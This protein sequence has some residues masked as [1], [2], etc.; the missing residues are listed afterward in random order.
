M[1][2]AP[3]FGRFFLNVGTAR[4]DI[5]RVK[6]KPFDHQPPIIKDE[7]FKLQPDDGLPARQLLQRV[8]LKRVIEYSLLVWFDILQR[9]A[10]VIILDPKLGLFRRFA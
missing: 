6:T 1:A 8:K 7:V 9:K 10:N 5:S 3:V 2:T 4:D